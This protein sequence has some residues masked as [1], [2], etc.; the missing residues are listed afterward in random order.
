MNGS[1]TDSTAPTPDTSNS[2]HCPVFADFNPSEGG[3]RPCEWVTTYD[4]LRSQ[5]RWIRSEVGPRGFYVPT[6]YEDILEVLQSHDRFSN[7]AVTVFDPEPTYKWIPLMLD[8]PEHTEWRRLLAPFFSPGAIKRLDGRIEACAVDLIEPLIDRGQCDYLTDFAQLFPT[9]IFL[10]I[11]GLPGSELDRFMGWEKA[12]LHGDPTTPE[13]HEIYLAAM[14][15]VVSYFQELIARRR[16]DSSDDLLSY[17]LNFEFDGQP[18]SEPDLLALC[19]LMFL[20]GLDTVTHTLTYAMLHLA[21][22]PADRQLICTDATA[23]ASAVEEFVRTY[24]IVI[25]ARKATVDT[26]VGGQAF[27]AGDMVSIPYNSAT[28]GQEPDGTEF[29]IGRGNNSH[30]GFGAGPHRCLGSHLAR[31]E[32]V[33]AISEWH[34]RIP[35]YLLADEDIVEHGGILG[36]DRL[37]LMWS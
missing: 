29:K 27:K 6:R 7:A 33:V 21:R 13:G 23:V 28:R 35:D 8:P 5:H 17:A 32:L 30:L 1:I 12:I 18:V 22:N 16:S 3:R 37:P 4:E 25:S 9:T 11:F 14:G 15:E 20:A 24:N 34:K 19:L 26:T 2:D 10:E 36:L 31:R